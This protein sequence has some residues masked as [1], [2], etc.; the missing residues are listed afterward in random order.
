MVAM[1]R[2]STTGVLGA[3]ALA[4][5]GPARA[6][7]ALLGRLVAE[8]RASG[9]RERSPL[10]LEG[11]VLE[12][13]GRAA[14]GAVVV[15]S[16]GGEAVTDASGR[17]VLELDAPLDAVSLRIT[18][19]GRAGT[20]LLASTSVE[21]ATV[22]RFTQL[23][24]LQLAQGVSC[25]SQWLPTFGG[26]PGTDGIVEALAVFD[27]GGGPEL[28]VGGNFG[29]AGGVSAARIAKWDGSSWSSVGEG[30]DDYVHALVV[31]DDGGGPALY[32][33]GAFTAAG[34]APANRIAKWDGASWSAL[35]AGLD[36]AVEALAVYD[37][38]G[39]PALHAGGNF[40][41]RIAKWSG[42]S[43]STV[44]GGIVTGN[45]RALTVFD[46]GVGSALFAGG[47]FS[48]VA[49]VPASRVA[50]WNG[51]SWSGLATGVN[52]NV[53]AL[54]V[55]D[56]GGGPKLHVGGR[57]TQAGGAPANRVARWNGASWSALG[58]GVND[59]VYGL[60]AFDGGVGPRLYATGSFTAAGGS[61]AKSIARWDGSAWVGVS[62]G[63]NGAG[64]VL[65]VLDDG[66]GPALFAG[67]SFSVAGNV[68]ANSVAKWNGTSWTAFGNGLGQAVECLAVYYDGGGP[69]L[70]A[71]GWFLSAGG[72]PANRIAKWN[73]TSWSALG[74]GLNGI[75]MAMV[76]HDD[77]SGPALYVAGEF[78]AAGG[79]TRM[80]IARWNGVSWSTVGVALNNG[81]NSVVHALAV[82]DDG[83][84]P[85]LYVGGYFSSAGGMPVNKVARW[86]GS[87]WSALGSSVNDAVLALAVYDDGGGPALY[88]G[89][90][91]STAGGA[92]AN[93][94]AKWDGA[95]WSPLGG[96]V[97]GPSSRVEALEVYDDGNGPA[98][99]VGGTFEVAGPDLASCIARWDG[100]SWTPLG[101][102]L[103]GL[104]PVV[105][106]LEAFDDGSGP[107]LY[108]GG[109][110]TVAGGVAA[111]RIARWDGSSWS[112]LGA[113]WSS[114][115]MTL[116][117]V[118]DGDRLALHV[119]GIENPLPSGDSYIAKWGCPDHQ[120]PTISHP[121]SV[122]AI[123]RLGSAPGE[124]VTFVVTATDDQ[125]PSPVV[126]CVPPSGSLFPPGTTLVDCTAT[127]ASGNESTA[128]FPVFVRSSVDQ[129]KP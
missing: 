15:S 114:S 98:L 24:P 4:L 128:Q 88:A 74:S 109:A 13:G 93:R 118:D 115:V 2:W 64:R 103:S 110:F 18:A 16:A 23:G 70:H 38:G 39:G 75:P 107:G 48:F 28:Y 72:V 119:G 11:F 55:F 92:P 84:G 67:G 86:D 129:R 124:V 44:G 96:G 65:A 68:G 8:V 5:A 47:S 83:S 112:P 45:V 26:Q 36:G 102:G 105:H 21:L 19:A 87:S 62:G 90:R 40:S 59:D 69:A 22:T 14:E 77:G 52:D 9:A 53:E 113:G 94:I 104:S 41:G 123:D 1:V 101:S 29:G 66:G 78:T 37:D 97:T 50:K 17:Y 56:D 58:S 3:A 35:G 54:A 32:V 99:Y 91:F 12:P 80:R 126:V 125:D 25:L 100:S 122:A 71:G 81:L 20:N 108:A 49:G 51:A 31:L 6:Q 33:G 10:T 42:A 76:T 127:D 57:F 46:D 34:G 63:L 82:Y 60:A 95:S 106:A 7:G 73:G 61:A 43:W 79:V 111:N 116:L 117:A 27:D 30:L 120:A 121:A 85:A 89:G